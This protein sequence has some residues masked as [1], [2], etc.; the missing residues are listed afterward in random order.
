MTTTPFEHSPLDS[1]D[2]RAIQI[3]ELLPSR[4][5]KGPIRCEL[6]HHS[7]D[8]DVEYE[9][10][11]Y[12]W[13]EPEPGHT[14]L[15]NGSHT[16]EVTP[17]CIQAMSCLRRR[18]HRRTL[19][20]DA[21]CIDQRENDASRRDRERQVKIMS[22]IYRKAEKVLVWLGPSESTSARTIARLKLIAKVNAVRESTDLGYSTLCDLQD[23]LS[24]GM[25]EQL[26]VSHQL[27]F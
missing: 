19:W 16:L 10:L 2:P 23:R 1:A 18:F 4:N 15:V 17:N 5:L 25:S 9:A 11:S 24:F 8:Q 20:I 27:S 26:T 7:L 14:V 6:H 22:I 21:I 12:T 3:L 13:G